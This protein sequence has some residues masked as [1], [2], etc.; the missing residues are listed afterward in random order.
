M[1]LDQ[2]VLNLIQI[3]YMQICYIQFCVKIR[4]FHVKFLDILSSAR[5]GTQSF[6]ARVQV[7]ARTGL[8]NLGME[9]LSR[10]TPSN[11]AGTH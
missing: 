10:N 8:S 2:F 5:T 11:L 7:R 6:P 3:C 1:V 9:F 4:Q